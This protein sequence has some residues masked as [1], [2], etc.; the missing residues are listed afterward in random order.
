MQLDEQDL[1]LIRGTTFDFELGWQSENDQ[2]A[3]VPVDING[4]SATLQIRSQA[5]NDLLVECTSVAGEITITDATLGQLKVHIAP[6]KTSGQSVDGW[7]DARWELRITF[8]SGDVYSLV[9]GWAKL[10]PGVVG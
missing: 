3:M 10:I 5:N 9:R 7:S 4:C 1:N 8:S 6:E 2:G